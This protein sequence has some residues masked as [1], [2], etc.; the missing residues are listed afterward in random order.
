[1]LSTS[2]P[3][4]A[5]LLDVLIL[6]SDQRQ[7]YRQA[8]FGKNEGM[9]GLAARQQKLE[10]RYTKL[11]QKEQPHPLLVTAQEQAQ[12]A[13]AALQSSAP[14]QA[15]TCLTSNDEALRHFIVAQAIL[16]NTAVVPGSSSS[17][18]VIDA[19]RLRATSMSVF[20]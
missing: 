6:A 8:R 2:P 19:S 3:E 9:A 11:N 18:P 12:Q 5:E 20:T 16:L 17:E 10:A 13:I 4:L 7:I 15:V 1:M 14:D